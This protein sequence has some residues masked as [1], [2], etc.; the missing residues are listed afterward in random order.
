MSVHANTY[1]HTNVNAWN[2]R[3]ECEVRTSCVEVDECECTCCI[4][5]DECAGTCWVEITYAVQF[6]V[7]KEIPYC[8]VCV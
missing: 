3:N 8:F 7:M 1:V 5:M 6:I 2:E 4:E